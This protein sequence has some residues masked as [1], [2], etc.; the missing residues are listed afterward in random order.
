MRVSC[1][2]IISFFVQAIMAQDS[3]IAIKP[4]KGDGIFSLLRRNGLNPTEYYGTFLELNKDRLKEGN[5]LD[6]TLEYMIPKLDSLSYISEQKRKVEEFA[7]FGNAY[8]EVQI[9]S[10]E[11]EHTVFYLVSGHG[12]P[13]PGAVSVYDG[14]N[15]AEDEYAYDLT[16]RLGRM[17]IA[18]GA[19]VYF[20]VQDGNDGIRDDF[21]L[22]L[23]RDEKVYPNKKI[24]L[25]HL[26]RLR[27]RTEVIN[28]LYLDNLGQHQ[29][30]L[31]IHVDS[32]SKSENIDVFFY[33]HEN[34]KK[35]ERL[36]KSI[37]ETFVAKYGEFQPNRKYTGTFSER[38]ELYLVKNTLPAM[39]YIE[40]GNI[41]NQLDRKRILDPENREALAKWIFKGVKVDFITSQ[42]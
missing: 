28:E 8:K 35:G 23:D 38:S 16:L 42:Q 3:I 33:H 19:K 4:R 34:S 31:V 11:L 41:K 13:D 7:I 1:F 29:R 10:D 36:A 37:H 14:K 17:L 21:Y 6:I 15:I 39:V 2:L 5:L 25:N 18:D 22:K 40:I 9:L 12:G 20:I 30:L 26:A 24:P 27:Q 32:R